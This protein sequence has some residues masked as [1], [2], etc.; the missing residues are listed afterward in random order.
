MLGTGIAIFAVYV[1]RD[2]WY[3]GGLAISLQTI[4]LLFGLMLQMTASMD[5]RED[6]LMVVKLQNSAVNTAALNQRT[7][8]QEHWTAVISEMIMLA[9]L[10]VLISDP[11]IYA[12]DF[13]KYIAIAPQIGSSLVVIPAAF[14]VASLVY[15]L[16]QPLTK[17]YHR[18]LKAYVRS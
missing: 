1:F 11:L 5:L 4:L 10:S 15:S 17:K 3:G 18:R 13:E 12:M 9:V 6:I 14:L 8:R 2:S 7:R 16:R